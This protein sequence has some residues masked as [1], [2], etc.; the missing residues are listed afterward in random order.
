MTEYLSAYDYCLY[1]KD[2]ELLWHFNDAL[3]QEPVESLSNEPRI[4][5]IISTF[6]IDSHEIQECT[7]MNATKT[8][9]Q[10]Q[11]TALQDLGVYG[12]PTVFVDGQPLVG[13]RPYR[14]YKSLLRDNGN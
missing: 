4:L 11:L 13:P 2:P 14:T 1:E 3:F 12:T 9:V 5:E 10:E 7:T 6:G 8:R